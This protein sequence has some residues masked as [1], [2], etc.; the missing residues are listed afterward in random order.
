MQYA[1]EN[2]GTSQDLFGD[3]VDS[4]T[5][6]AYAYI[7]LR[8]DGT[9][10]FHTLDRLD[11]RLDD[12]QATTLLREA[13]P[14]RPVDVATDFL[15]YV[16]ETLFETLG[17]CEVGDVIDSIPIDFYFTTTVIWGKWTRGQL[18]EAIYQAGYGSRQG[19]LDTVWLT[20]EPEAAAAACLAEE[21]SRFK[22]NDTIIVL[23]CGVRPSEHLRISFNY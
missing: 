19:Q 14:K 13:G 3:S 5:S 2:P 1:S 10:G 18:L 4:S 8:L 6:L 7:K 9:I 16:Y 12:S 15:A 11:L 21:L 22:A 20:S 17:R 23:D